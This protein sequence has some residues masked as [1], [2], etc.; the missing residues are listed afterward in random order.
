MPPFAAG[1]ALP[2]PGAG[3]APPAGGAAGA[4]PEPVPAI[5]S[6]SSVADLFPAAAGAD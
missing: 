2:A 4:E 5:A 6:N 3:V 1:G